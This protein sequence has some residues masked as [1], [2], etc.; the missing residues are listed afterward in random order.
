MLVSPYVRCLKSSRPIS[1]LLPSCPQSLPN[2]EYTH[3]Q[4]KS[5]NRGVEEEIRDPELVNRSETF[6]T[7]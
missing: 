2:Q 4:R 7:S 6:S 5:E 1:H 3:T